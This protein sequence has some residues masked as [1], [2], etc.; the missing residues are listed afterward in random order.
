MSYIIIYLIE[1]HTDDKRNQLVANFA[2]CSGNTKTK[3]GY[4]KTVESCSNACSKTTNMFAFGRSARYK[5]GEGYFCVCQSS[6]Q[7]GSCDMKFNWGYDLY[8]IS[9]MIPMH[10]IQLLKH[11]TQLLKHCTQSLMHGTHLLMHSTQLL[12]HGSQLLTHGT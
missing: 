9:K 7:K 3:L 8:S 11:C 5:S 4:F 2:E 10:C 6:E 1:Q 12:L